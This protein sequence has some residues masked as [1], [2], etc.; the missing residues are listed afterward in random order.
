MNIHHCYTL[1]NLTLAAVL[2]IGFASSALAQERALFVDL[3]SKEATD[4]GTL[5]GGYY[6]DARGISDAGQVVG[7]SATDIAQHAFLTG[8]NGVGMTDLG[9][10]GGDF[11]YAYGINNAGQV[12]GASSPD[13]IGLHA[14]ITGPDGV[15]M[16]DLG[17]LTEHHYSEA[18]GINDA[19]Q[20]VGISGTDNSPQH[21]FI[22]G[23]NGVG[24]TDL[25]TLGGV[26]SRAYGIND[27]GQVVGE[28]VTA[29]GQH[30]AFITGLNGVGMV[31]L[32]SL[33]HLPTGFT[34]FRATAI[35]NH[36]QLAAV[37]DV[38]VVPE[39]EMY[40]MLLSGLGLMGFLAR[41][42]ATA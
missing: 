15:G 40:A 38:P 6:S 23:P 12:V 33:V 17:T 28:Y 2:T 29:N 34:N 7:I 25:G 14:F 24:M 30:H 39:P 11:S 18:R 32:A 22:T 37:G 35:N 36:G 16:T 27:M 3:N 9:T 42:R 13:N 10:V 1:R 31:D 19:R 26:E 21:A 41:R 5:A 8:P 20:V 4:L